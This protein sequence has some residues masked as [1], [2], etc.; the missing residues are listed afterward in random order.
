MS[1]K[2]GGTAICQKAGCENASVRKQGRQHLCPLHYRFRQMRALAKSRGLYAPAD[3]ELQRIV[4][5][6]MD[7]PDCGR[8][9][10]WL[11]RDGQLLVATLQH[12]RDGTLAIVCRSCNTRHAYM[13][14]DSYRDMP[15]DS[16]LC[17][18][19]M[20]IKPES[21]FSKDRS[22]SG[23]RQ[24]KSKCKTCS[25]IHG[26]QWRVGNRGKYNEYQRNYRAAR[27]AEG[28]PVRG[29]AR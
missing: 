16:K 4:P 25:D 28:N 15:K 3:D 27:K 26:N 18:C 1:I 2:D 6:A 10:N 21:E 20:Q 29:G 17:P 24:I 8:K 9:M 19:C 7:C 14:G 22:R 13:P 23:E 11:A 5:A 12:Y